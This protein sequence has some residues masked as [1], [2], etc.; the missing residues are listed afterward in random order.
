LASSLAACLAIAAGSLIAILSLWHDAQSHLALLQAEQ[1]EHA[2]TSAQLR[3]S[4]L[5]YALVTL[6][7]ELRRS[8]R[9]EGPRDQL[10]LLRQFLLEASRNSAESSGDAL[11]QVALQAAQHSVLLATCS[12]ADPAEVKLTSMRQGIAAWQ[13]IAAAE[14]GNSRWPRALAVHLMTFAQKEPEADWL[15]WHDPDNRWAPLPRATRSLA[16][17][18]YAEILA[19]HAQHCADSNPHVATDMFEAADVLTASL[20]DRFVSAPEVLKVQLAVHGG[21]ARTKTIVGDSEAVAAQLALLRQRL[22]RAPAAAA[23]PPLLARHVADGYRRLAQFEKQASG[24]T[25]GLEHLTTATEYSERACGAALDLV[26][27]RLEHAA[28][29]RRLSRRHANNGDQDA[30]EQLLVRA[31]SVLDEALALQRGHREALLR[32][33]AFAWQ[34]ADMCLDRGDAEQAAPWLESATTDYATVGL[35]RTDAATDFGFAIRA[36]QFWGDWCAARGERDAAFA[37]HQ[38]ALDLLESMPAN[39]RNGVPFSYLY[40]R[41]RNAQDQLRVSTTDAPL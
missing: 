34:L 7:G 32:R 17:L 24:A 35:C 10:A 18:P 19:S 38:R 3:S 31:V 26:P 29:L 33:A 27:R 2:G 14:P 36:W 8:G 12:L 20:D 25:G 6:E 13:C 1:H 15:W 41:G 23:C 30:A 39:R 16:A 40:E 22:R 9:T 11:M 28:D 37:S 5:N 21:L 4:L